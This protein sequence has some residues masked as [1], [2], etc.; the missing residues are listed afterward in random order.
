[1]SLNKVIFFVIAELLNKD[2]RPLLI[3]QHLRF[4]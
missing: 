1:M 4:F 3:T 2:L